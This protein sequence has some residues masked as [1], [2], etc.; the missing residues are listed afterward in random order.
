M[1]RN[2]KQ[3]CNKKGRHVIRYVKLIQYGLCDVPSN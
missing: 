3:G 1:H 2:A